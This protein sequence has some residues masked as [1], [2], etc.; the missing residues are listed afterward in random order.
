MCRPR[1][2]STHASGPWLGPDGTQM[3]AFVPS[4]SAIESRAG[5]DGLSSPWGRAEQEEGQARCFSRWPPPNPP[6]PQASAGHAHGAS[7]RPL[8]GVARPHS[9]LH[10]QGG[11]KGA[12][13][14]RAPFSGGALRP[15]PAG[16]MGWSNQLSISNSGSFFHVYILN[17]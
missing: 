14:G 13:T 12:G 11:G 4:S 6:F 5:A 1:G 10:L 17:S 3:D 2:G 8:A 15:E 16:W 7:G 9:Q